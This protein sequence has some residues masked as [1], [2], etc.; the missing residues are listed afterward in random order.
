MYSTQR[1]GGMNLFDLC[2][3]IDISINIMV[4]GKQSIN[5]LQRYV[6]R[7]RYL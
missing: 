2:V 6:P 5:F 4:L 3:Y 7:P 1:P